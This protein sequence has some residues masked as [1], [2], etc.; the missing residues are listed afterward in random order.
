MVSLKYSITKEDYIN[1]Y[2]YVVWDAPENRKKRM[3]YYVKQLIPILLFIFAFYYTG[4]FQRNSTFILLILA[5]IFLTSALSLFG[6]RSNTIKQGEKITNDPGNS[7]IFLER[8][9][10][11]SDAGIV[12]KDA[13][14]EINYHWNA[15]VKKQE[16]KEYYFL[17]ISS[18]QA[19]IVPKRV[20]NNATERIQ[21]EKILTQHLSFDAEIGYLI[22]S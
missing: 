2:T 12:S 19:L 16:S 5:F 13:L 8:S 21:F 11:V 4:I 17:F 3:W 7:S 15:F 20:F 10:L 6:V 18:I 14:V 9:L 1:Y 22:K